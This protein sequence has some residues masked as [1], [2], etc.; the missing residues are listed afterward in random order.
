MTLQIV[1]IL[2]LVPEILFLLGCV[3]YITEYDSIVND[4]SVIDLWK[5]VSFCYFVL[6]LHFVSN[7]NNRKQQ[8]AVI[9]LVYT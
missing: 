2:H 6:Q 4:I 8:D 7:Q 1:T 5:S 3:F 9:C